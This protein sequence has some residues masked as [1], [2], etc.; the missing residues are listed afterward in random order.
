MIIIKDNDTVY[1]AD[2]TGYA[3]VTACGD[4]LWDKHEENLNVWKI[5]NDD[6]I[7]VGVNP[8][9]G[10]SAD[11]FRYDPDFVRGELTMQKLM[12]E[13][14]PKIKNRLKKYGKTKENGT[15]KDAFCFAQGDRAFVI[16]PSWDC[17]CVD[18]FEVS[19]YNQV[20]LSAL[21]V[22]EGMPPEERL[23]FV[24]ETIQAERKKLLFPLV[25]I[26]TKTCKPYFLK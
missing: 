23:R 22:S 25:V 12:L 17:D 7:I 6:N 20:S 21:R 19:G 3:L 26:N 11:L 18:R 8:Y 10:L 15:I 5:P 24:A 9:S 1:F 4:S 13:V 2:P 16:R 14:V